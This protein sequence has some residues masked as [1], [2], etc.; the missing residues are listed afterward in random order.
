MQVESFWL[1]Q[2]MRA[3]RSFDTDTQRQGAAS[4]AREHTS[5]GVLPVRAGQLQRWAALSRKIERTMYFRLIAPFLAL[6]TLVGCAAP[7][8][9]IR[10]YEGTLS[11]SSS[12][13]TLLPPKAA[14]MVL[15]VSGKVAGGSCFT[16]CMFISPVHVAPGTHKFSSTNMHMSALDD[17]KVMLSPL[18]LTLDSAFKIRQ[19]GNTLLVN[20]FSFEFEQDLK[21]GK[22][23]VLQVG[24]KEDG[25]KSG[26]YYVWWQEQ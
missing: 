21:E 3:N 16:N 11:S 23:Y 24:H 9:P 7:R 17:K 12:V 15:R 26:Q 13:V 25:T 14:Y 18:P 4:R 5:R 10:L 19:T 1:F 2:A 6:L 8:E 20:G 22:A